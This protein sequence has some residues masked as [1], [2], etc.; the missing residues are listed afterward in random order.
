M[1]GE[2]NSTGEW[3]VSVSAVCFLIRHVFFL[4]SDWCM[5]VETVDDCVDGCATPLRNRPKS[6]LSKSVTGAQTMTVGICW[7]W[8]TS[9]GGECATTSH[10][11]DAIE[12][13]SLLVF[14]NMNFPRNYVGHFIHRVMTVN[15]ETE[16]WKYTGSIS[17]IDNRRPIYET[18]GITAVN[19]L[20]LLS[21]IISNPRRHWR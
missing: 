12:G 21:L 16:M 5:I 8:C 14:S 1:I 11:C 4:V 10:R 19:I 6:W 18:C 2:R 17:I 9:E 3:K 20:D 13:Q 7:G 15:G